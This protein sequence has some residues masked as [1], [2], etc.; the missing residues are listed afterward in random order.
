[1]NKLIWSCRIFY[2]GAMLL[3][4]FVLDY[5]HFLILNIT[6]AYIPFEIA[7]FLHNKK[8]PAILF[9]ILAVAWLVFFPNAF[10]LVT[11]FFHLKQFKIYDY[12]GIL[13]KD[14]LLWQSFT[15]MA[16]TVF[17]GLF[18]G[19]VSLR[20]IL[21]AIKERTNWREAILVPII[22]LLSSYGIYLGRF[23]RLHTVHILTE[24][25]TVIRSILDVSSFQFEF[26]IYF[27]IL[28][29]MLYLMFRYFPSSRH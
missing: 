18:V 9:W 3:L 25:G 24:P 4:F 5:Y 22:L 7:V 26:I 13:Q 21:D 27:F 19:N 10:Y 17:F 12:N 1:M 29:L 15:V 11:D 8:R 16:G 14:S 6:L 2:L 28:Q 23:D 20:F